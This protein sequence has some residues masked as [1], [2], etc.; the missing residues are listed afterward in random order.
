LK[1]QLW[2]RVL[3]A[4]DLDQFG[5]PADTGD[6]RIVPFLEIDFW[7]GLWPGR[8]RD[9]CQARFKIA[10]KLIGALRRADDGAERADRREDASDVTLVE[11]VDGDAGAHEI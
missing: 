7:L 9:A 5:H 11:D 1:P 6:Q 8:C 2:Q 3:A 10:R 4:G